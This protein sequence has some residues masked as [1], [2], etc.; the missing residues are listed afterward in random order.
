MIINSVMMMFIESMYSTQKH[1]GGV[2]WPRKK[3]SKK[4][5]VPRQCCSNI[6]RKY[7]DVIY[8]Y[9]NNSRHFHPRMQIQCMFQLIQRMVRIEEDQRN[10]KHVHVPVIKEADE[11]ASE[12]KGIDKGE[13]FCSGVLPNKR[14]SLHS[15]TMAIPCYS[16]PI[17]GVCDQSKLQP[18][19]I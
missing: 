13:N 9:L 15:I 2:H 4:D 1:G 14:L 5:K 19:L 6:S 12:P 7:Y 16:Y 11:V 18:C 10:L 8:A 3:R 17:R